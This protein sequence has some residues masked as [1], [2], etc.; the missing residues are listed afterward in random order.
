MTKDK[1]CVRR[2]LRTHPILGGVDIKKL[3]SG[4]LIFCVVFVLA[5]VYV[6][7]QASQPIEYEDAV[8]LEMPHVVTVEIPVEEP[9]FY[10]SVSVTDYERELLAKLAYAEAGNQSLLGQM[11]VIEVVMN[12]VVSDLFPD[13]VEDVIYQSDPVQFSTASALSHITPTETQYAAVDAVLSEKDPI[14]PQD[15]MY[16]ATY[17]FREVYEQIGDHYFCY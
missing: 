17:P 2:C 16:F 13:T 10:N 14:L 5:L 7:V 8:M 4:S 11:A 12:R 15:V 6:H 3:I 1:A 9:A